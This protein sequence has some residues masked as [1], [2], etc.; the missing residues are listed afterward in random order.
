MAVA[1]DEVDGDLLTIDELAAAV[2]TTVRTT[3]YYASLGLVPPPVRRGR[4]A[5]YG[6]VH[7]ARLELVRALQDHGFTL[8][9]AERVLAAI[10]AEATV[11]QL[12]LQ[13][14]MLT[15]WTSQPP[16][17]LTRRALDK[18]A[19]RRLSDDD[20]ELLA[21]DASVVKVS[22]R[23]LPYVVS[24]GLH[25][26]TTVASTMRLAALAGISVFVTGGLGG[27]HRGAE[28]SYDVSADLTELSTTSV[29]VVCAGVKSILDIGLTLEKLE[30]LGVPVVAFRSGTLPAFYARE[31]GLPLPRVDELAGLVDLLRA[32]EALG[33]PGGLV[34]A[35][36]PPDDLAL[37]AAD[38]AAWI[39][40]ALA[41][42]RVRGIVGRDETPFLLAELA[43]RSDGRTVTL[44]E[45][46]VLGYARLAARLAAAWCD[47]RG[48]T[49]ARNSA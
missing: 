10:P 16:E 29:A 6:P 31:S 21:S 20:L 15:S 32:Q 28:T 41:E 12:A 47:A 5:Y 30:T 33:W 9:A 43:R 2:G 45:E 1:P 26:A 23:D 7:R 13:R 11:E 19:G 44:N 27:V 25:G 36:P 48:T 14:A 24:R 22:I 8:Q 4:I 18:R 49:V 39:A 34:I 37:P 46:L 40:G 42:A 38:L 35:N 3:R 17:V